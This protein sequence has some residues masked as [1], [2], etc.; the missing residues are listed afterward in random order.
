MSSNEF[1]VTKQNLNFYFSSIAKEYAKLSK[2]PIEVIVVGG[3]AV[4]AFYDFRVGSFDI[5]VIFYPK[6]DALKQAINNVSDKLNL[7]NGW[8]NDSFKFTTSFTDRIIGYSQYYKTYSNLLTLRVVTG[9]YLIAIKLLSGR[10]YKNDQS[11]IIGI[12]KEERE[13]GRNLTMKDISTAMERLYGRQKWDEVSEVTMQTL[14]NAL[15]SG[16]DL[17]ELFDKTKQ[18]EIKKAN[19]VK[20]F[21]ESKK[22]NPDSVSFH[23]FL[24]EVSKK[25]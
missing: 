22:D 9:E 23:D 21:K 5:D 2:N 14:K 13:K 17:S 10:V 1:Y 25:F 18:R 6:S 4:I 20:M 16:E 8:I 19:Q 24:E 3:A 11:D 12:V 7:P 15:E